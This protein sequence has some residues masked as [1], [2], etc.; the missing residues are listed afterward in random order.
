MGIRQIPARK[1]RSSQKTSVLN[2]S[3]SGKALI[4]L[5]KDKERRKRGRQVLSS[6]TELEFK[7][8]A[9]IVVS[10]DLFFL[11]L[12]VFVQWSML[13]RVKALN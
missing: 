7:L 9:K 13:I 6:K 8:V 1:G 3:T 2:F 4:Q 10:I 12:L 5:K 11:N